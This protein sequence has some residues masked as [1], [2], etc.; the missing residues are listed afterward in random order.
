M[1]VN[2]LSRWSLL[3]ALVA[4]WLSVN[5]AGVQSQPP[6]TIITSPA[7]RTGYLSRAVLWEDPGVISPADLRNGPPGMFPFTFD[8][9]TSAEGI[10]CAFSKPGKSLGGKSQKFSCVGPGDHTMRL[11]YWDQERESGNRETFAAVAATR[12]M[13]ALGFV[14]TAALP[15]NVQCQGCPEDPMSGT[16]EPR[17]RRYVAMWQ[18]DVP[19]PK[20][21]SG[22][23][24]DQGWEWRELDD[25]I[26]ALPPG[27]A[28]A[29]QRT[30]FGALTLLGVL[31][32]HGD[33]KPEQQALYCMDGI[34]T[35][36]GDFRP[37]SNSGREDLYEHPGATSCNRAAAVVVDVGA[38][39]GGA[40]RT[41][42]GTT[43]KMN[44]ESWREKSIFEKGGGVCHGDLT[45]SMAAGGGGEGHPVISEEGRVFLLDQLH[46]LTVDPLRAVF[47]AARVDRI[48][49]PR[50]DGKRPESDS[51]DEW[52]ATFQQKVREIEARRCSSES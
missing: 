30:L 40:G 26:R 48:H 2:I 28:R 33:R 1:S 6:H 36:A 11:K 32:Q 38:T 9:G 46:R 14:A 23:D 8:E 5:A 22:S 51:V 37:Q 24:N 35:T 44:L 10:T 27:D 29:R 50:S 7:A 52:I 19:G 3:V 15:M 13:W 20:I 49:R 43:A 45:I 16:G 21:V 12:L 34:D 41:S 18:L 47:E 39:F 31:M 25:A 42:N 17:M 4:V